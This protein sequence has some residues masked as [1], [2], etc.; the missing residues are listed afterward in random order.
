MN[1]ENSATED[2][3]RSEEDVNQFVSGRK[4]S[5]ATRGEMEQERESNKQRARERER[6]C[7]DFDDGRPGAASRR[8]YTTLVILRYPS[9]VA[10]TPLHFLIV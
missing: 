7:K 10:A 6:G 4:D 1:S 5:D 3:M 8:R 9:A 2:G